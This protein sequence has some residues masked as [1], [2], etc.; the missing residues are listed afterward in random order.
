M[1]SFVVRYWMVNDPIQVPDPGVE[2]TKFTVWT[3][4]VNHGHSPERV[5]HLLCHKIQ[6]VPEIRDKKKKFKHG[7]ERWHHVNVTLVYWRLVLAESAE[8]MHHPANT[9]L[10]PLGSNLPWDCWQVWLL[11]SL[12]V[13]ILFLTSSETQQRK[14]YVWVLNSPAT[15]GKQTAV[16]RQAQV[17]KIIVGALE[18]IFRK[19]SVC[20]TCRRREGR[21]KLN[22]DKTVFLTERVCGPVKGRRI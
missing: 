4:S 1:F 14:P 12:T 18:G 22:R 21:R 5:N 16:Q 10:W 17:S 13:D 15:V 20:F 11:T 8:N 7:R 6:V 9:E 3:A 2:D 19:K